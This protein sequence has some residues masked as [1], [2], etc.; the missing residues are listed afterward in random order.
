MPRRDGTG[1]MGLGSKTG[2]GLGPCKGEI[3]KSNVIAGFGRAF[4]NRRGRGRGFG[5]Y[6]AA[7]Q[8]S[9]MT[10]KDILLGKGLFAKTT[11]QH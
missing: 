8:A 11:Q 3:D 10:K 7:N 6:F 4:G 1:P 5:R 9:F 2:R